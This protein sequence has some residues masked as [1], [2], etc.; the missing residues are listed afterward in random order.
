PRAQPFRGRERRDHAAAPKRADLGTQEESHLHEIRQRL[1]PAAV[2]AVELRDHPV[3]CGIGFDRR[4]DQ[5]GPALWP[6]PREP[7]PSTRRADKFLPTLST[8][9]WVS[10]YWIPALAA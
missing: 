9:T 7:G 8:S 4:P 6:G 5:A 10:G 1:D 2:A 3:G